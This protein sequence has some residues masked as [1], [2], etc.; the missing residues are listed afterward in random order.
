MAVLRPLLGVV[1]GPPFLGVM[2]LDIARLH[3]VNRIGN[4]EPR[5]LRCSE[6]VLDNSEFSVI[7]HDRMFENS[8]FSVILRDRIFDNSE[9]SGERSAGIL[10]DSEFSQQ[11]SH[12]YIRISESR[13]PRFE[14][15]FSHA[16]VSEISL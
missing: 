2:D 7:L 5:M 13:N 10:L 9:L 15:E 16:R 11:R 3:N 4:S 8:E 6:R 1:E 14:R 12:C